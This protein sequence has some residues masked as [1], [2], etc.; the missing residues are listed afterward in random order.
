MKIG[1]FE[2]AH[3][4]NTLHVAWAFLREHLAATKYTS[5]EFEEY[6]H[7]GGIQYG[8]AWRYSFD[9]ETAKGNAARAKFQV[10]IHRTNGGLYHA[11]A[12]IL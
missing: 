8:Q 1:Q 7:T 11:D 9:L 12:Y 3:N 10:Q 4:M 2:Q 5:R 6:M